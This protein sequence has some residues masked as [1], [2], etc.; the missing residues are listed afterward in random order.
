[1]TPIEETIIGYLNNGHLPEGVNAYAEEPT[2]KRPGS[3]LAF[4]LVMDTGG[5]GRHIY[6]S[7]IAVQSY[8]P[9]K[10]RAAQLNEVVKAEME[11]LP[12]LSEITDSVL[13]SSYYYP[14]ESRRRHRYQCV[15]DVTHY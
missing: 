3:S 7:K 6:T 11:S 8:A 14:D 12:E 1:M 2:D 10:Y 4:I 13:D 9:T 15:F 5:G